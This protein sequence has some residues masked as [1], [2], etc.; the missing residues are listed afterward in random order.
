[1][2]YVW[3]FFVLKSN[4]QWKPRAV[5]WCTVFPPKRAAQIMWPLVFLQSSSQFEQHVLNLTPLTHV[6]LLAFMDFISN[7]YIF[8]PACLF[9]SKQN[10][11]S[12]P[13]TR[14]RFKPAPDGRRDVL[15]GKTGSS[16]VKSEILSVF[17][18]ILERFVFITM[19]YDGPRVFRWRLRSML[20]PAHQNFFLM[21]SSPY[22]SLFI[23]A[24][25]LQTSSCRCKTW[26]TS[27][28]FGSGLVC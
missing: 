8:A 20:S 17:L 23:R 27:E 25:M 1:M 11:L 24:K 6:A 26:S 2:L 18:E 15:T 21:T 9:G 10:L 16:G 28:T 14:K 13:S 19:V 4:L 7:W 22:E 5:Y 12:Y 3:F